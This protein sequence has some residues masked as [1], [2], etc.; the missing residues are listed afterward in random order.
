MAVQIR[1][2]LDLLERYV[3]TK[4]IGR[5]AFPT[6]LWLW[7]AKLGPI[8][9]KYPMMGVLT[10]W[11]AVPVVNAHLLAPPQGLWFAVLEFSCFVVSYVLLATPFS[12]VSKQLRTRERVDVRVNEMLATMH[13]RPPAGDQV[14]LPL[15]DGMLSAVGKFDRDGSVLHLLTPN[16]VY[17]CADAFLRALSDKE[18]ELI[19]ADTLTRLQLVAQKSPDVRAKIQNFQGS[20]KVILLDKMR[21]RVRTGAALREELVVPS[22]AEQSADTEPEGRSKSRASLLRAYRSACETALRMLR[23][24]RKKLKLQTECYRVTAFP[25]V[26]LLILARVADG[27]EQIGECFSQALPKEQ[28]G[29]MGGVKH[30]ASETDPEQFRHLIG[31]AEMLEV[32]LDG[33]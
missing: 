12:L 5:V 4:A 13:A 17:L 28:L 26:R 22:G 25:R 20:V 2:L 7:E 27:G 21:H 8:T 19:P 29:I 10:H 15:I 16:A 9:I 31:L 18:R 3:G 30:V 14:S 11:V 33:A 1:P 24:T 32:G 6:F 23:D